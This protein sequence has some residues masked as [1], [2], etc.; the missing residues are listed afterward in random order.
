MK[1]QAQ[2]L[3]PDQIIQTVAELAKELEMEIDE[4]LLAQK[5]QASSKEKDQIYQ[6]RNEK[7]ND[8]MSE[9]KSY[10][11][12]IKDYQNVIDNILKPQRKAI[13]QTFEDNKWKFDRLREALEAM[14]ERQFKAQKELQEMQ[15]RFSECN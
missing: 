13:H 4:N 12:K 14:N 10:E 8:I 11:K 2:I 6:K 7:L 5:F 1:Q 3:E 9:I 15:D